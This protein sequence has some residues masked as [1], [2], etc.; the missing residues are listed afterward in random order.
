MPRYWLRWTRHIRSPVELRAVWDSF[1]HTLNS[2][3]APPMAV[4]IMSKMVFFVAS[5]AS[6]ATDQ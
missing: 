2:S 3:Q 5:L 4:E 1:S 6:L